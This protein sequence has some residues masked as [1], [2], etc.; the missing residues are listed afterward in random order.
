MVTWM[1]KRYA[2][3]LELTFYPLAWNL[4][5]YADADGVTVRLGPFGMTLLWRWSG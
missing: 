2:P 1:R 3:A 4:Y 5:W